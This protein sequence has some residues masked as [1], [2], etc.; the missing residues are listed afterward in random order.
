MRIDNQ[1]NKQLGFSLILIIFLCFLSGI[2]VMLF[3]IEGILVSFVDLICA[4]IFARTI[5][6]NKKIRN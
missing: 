3:N 1:N 4:S 2:M 6:I 5:Y